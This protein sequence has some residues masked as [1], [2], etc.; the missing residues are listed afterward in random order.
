[1]EL[2]RFGTN[3]ERMEARMSGAATPSQWTYAEYARLP[4]DGN[5]YE[6]LDGDRVASTRSRSPPAMPT[7]EFRN[8]GS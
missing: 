5:R 7:L 4:D 2:P 8:I 3:I 6:V 1:M